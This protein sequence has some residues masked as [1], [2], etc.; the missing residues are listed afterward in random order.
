MAV[1]SCPR[2]GIDVD[3]GDGWARGGHSETSGDLRKWL[4]ERDG[5]VV[6]MCSDYSERAGDGEFAA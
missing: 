1:I 6:H 3:L 5:V 2:C 4:W